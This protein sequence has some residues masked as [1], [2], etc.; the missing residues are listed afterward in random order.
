M[1]DHLS[2]F[3][4]DLI[5]VTIVGESFVVSFI[6]LSQKSWTTSILGGGVAILRNSE[7]DLATMVHCQ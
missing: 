1:V 6:F 5:A 7:N 4:F 2:S 3:T